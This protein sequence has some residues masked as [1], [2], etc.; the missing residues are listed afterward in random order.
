M[1]LKTRSKSSKQHRGKI[2]KLILGN[3]PGAFVLSSIDNVNYFTRGEDN[4]VINFQPTYSLASTDCM[5]RTNNFTESEASEVQ[6][7]S[8]ASR[9]SRRCNNH[10][11]NYLSRPLSVSLPREKCP[12]CILYVYDTS[13]SYYANH[14]LLGFYLAVGNTCLLSFLF[15]FHL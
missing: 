8:L 11:P 12:V 3:S 2:G 10:H 9:G 15:Q 14:G 1:A 6:I 7:N 13:I 5:K 4:L